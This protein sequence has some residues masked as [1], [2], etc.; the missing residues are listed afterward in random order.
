MTLLEKLCEVN[1]TQGGT[2]HQY[3]RHQTQWHL[4]QKALLEYLSCGVTFDSK[5]AMEK[6]AG[7]Y[8]L[9]IYWE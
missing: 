1:G 2:I 5:K 6:L 9:V 3:F 8:G 7:W 4:M